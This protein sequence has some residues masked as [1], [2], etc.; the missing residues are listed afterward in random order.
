MRIIILLLCI[1]TLTSCKPD[2]K[3][4]PPV[5]YYPTYN[6]IDIK[7]GTMFNNILVSLEDYNSIREEPSNK[8]ELETATIYEYD[9]FEIETYYENNVEKIYSI[10][11][12]SEDFKTNENISIGNTKQDMINTYGNSYEEIENI[13]FIY[14]LSNTNLSFTLEN[15]IITEI[16]YYIS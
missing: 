2:S 11:I 4:T 1:I 15:D 13:I 5:E 12:T 8:N 10:R 14:K 7:P 9:Q 16:V 3:P 6:S